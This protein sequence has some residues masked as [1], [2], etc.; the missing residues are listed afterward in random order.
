MSGDI[1][2]IIG[3]TEDVGVA[4]CVLNSP[5]ERTV[6]LLFE[7]PEVAG[8]V[9]LVIAPNRGHEARWQR[10]FENQHTFLVRCNR[11][12]GMLINHFH[13]IA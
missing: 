8:T 11:R 2:D 7:V 4:V 1:D 10:G 9:T 3:P 6:E 5:V 13:P 12:S